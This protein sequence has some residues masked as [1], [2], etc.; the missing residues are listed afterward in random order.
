MKSD[1]LR[2]LTAINYL[3]QI[4]TTAQVEADRMGFFESFYTELFVLLL[5]N[6]PKMCVFF[7]SLVIYYISHIQVRP[8]QNGT[9]KSLKRM[10]G[11]V[12]C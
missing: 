6:V 3:I 7:Q 1:E 9:L 4:K 12:A 2:M 8:I 10:K 11:N 5:Y